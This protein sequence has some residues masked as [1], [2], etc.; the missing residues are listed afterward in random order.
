MNISVNQ[1][2]NNFSYIQSTTNEDMIPPLIYLGCLFLFGIPG[3]SLVVAVFGLRRK[4][5]AYRT[6]I[7]FLGVNDLLICSVTIPF[8]FYYLNYHMSFY[9]KWICK[10]FRSFNYMFVYNSVLVLQLMAIERFR[11]VCKPLKIQMSNKVG[12]IC[13]ICISIFSVIY[14]VPNLLIRGIHKVSLSRN[15]TGYECSTS[16]DYK[17]SILPVV[18]T[19]STL[20]ICAGH[21]TVF[22]IVYAC[23]GRQIY[24]HF[25]F[26]KSIN[27]DNSSFQEQTVDVAG[28]S[29]ST[30][31]E[32]TGDFDSVVKF[33]EHLQFSN[34]SFRRK[35]PSARTSQK[36]KCKR[37]ADAQNNKCTKIAILITSFFVVSYIP[38]LALSTLSGIYGDSF[39]AEHLSPPVL[40]FLQRTYVI[41]HVLNPVIYGFIDRRFRID[42]KHLTMQ[43]FRGCLCK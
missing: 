37:L 30:S 14:T 20:C 42:C 35:Y 18:Y 5:S 39:L 32:V 29:K 7:L 38:N 33:T 26:V 31:L 15:I 41:N 34:L 2:Q 13:I 4:P 22:I 8:E 24:R 1:S 6:I 25:I 10:V 21:I 40:H 12:R 27:P 11:R 3:N 19:L 43:L 9:N 23:I 28:H 17:H 36:I 16:D